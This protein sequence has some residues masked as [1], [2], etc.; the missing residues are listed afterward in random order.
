MSVQLCGLG[1]SAFAPL[2]GGVPLRA[3]VFAAER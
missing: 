1:E 3:Y 2:L